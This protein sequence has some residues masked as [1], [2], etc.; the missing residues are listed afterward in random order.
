MGPLAERLDNNN[1]H[2]LPKIIQLILLSSSLKNEI[3][4]TYPSDWSFFDDEGPPT[5]PPAIVGFI[6]AAAGMSEQDVKDCWAKVKDIAWSMPLNEFGE[7]NSLQLFKEF[8]MK[9]GF[10]EHSGRRLG[11]SLMIN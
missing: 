8:G 6:S 7:A 1:T 4:L 10:G 11:A 5:L 2:L 9:H 3:M